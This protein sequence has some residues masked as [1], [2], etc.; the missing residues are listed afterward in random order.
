MSA[1]VSASADNEWLPDERHCPSWCEGGHAQA[2]A[3]GCGWESSQEHTGDGGGAVLTELAYAGRPVREWG[4][5]WNLRAMQR[6]LGP[7]GGSWGPP[8][9]RLHV[10]ESDLHRR[11][12]IALTSGEARVLARQLEALADRLDLP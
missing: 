6:P 3:E 2:F 1:V 7:S 11:V 10:D 9:I 12:E 8:L 5:G 4:G